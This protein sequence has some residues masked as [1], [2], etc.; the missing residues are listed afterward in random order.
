MKHFFL[1]AFGLVAVLVAVPAAA[2]IYEVRPD[3]TGDF[4]TIQAAVEAVEDGDVIELT[5]GTFRGDGNRD[6]AFLG[7]EITIRSQSGSPRSCFVDCE[8]S[9][10]DRHRGFL[11]V[12]SENLSSVLEGITI[13]GGYA[14]EGGAIKGEG[15]SPTILNC[16]F[17]GNNAWLGGAIHGALFTP[18]LED[19]HFESNNA[20]ATAGALF[21]DNGNVYLTR[22]SFKQNLAEAGHGGGAIYLWWAG[23][24]SVTD[25]AFVGNQATLGGAISGTLSSFPSEIVR[26]TFSGN[27]AYDSA[28]GAIGLVFGTLRLTD[29]LFIGN[30]AAGTHFLDGGGG[31]WLSSLTLEMSGCTIAQN[32]SGAPGGGFI[33]DDTDGPITVQNSTFFGNSAPEASGFYAWSGDQVLIENSSITFGIG[34]QAVMCPSDAVI[35]CCDIYGNEGG[36]WVGPLEDDYGINGN[37]AANPLFCDP[38]DVGIPTLH[39]QASPYSL[40]TDSPCL[41]GNHPDGYDC[42]LIG[43]HGPACGPSSSQT[44][45]KGAAVE[46]T[47]WGRVKSGYR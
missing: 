26:C 1:H 12:N 25:C 20:S 23:L 31:L 15:A 39:S 2:T 29:C 27:V 4:P 40:H 32:S 16:A 17:I 35:Q 7:K 14:Y 36:D 22:C 5:N 30:Q 19:C 8:G 41:P 38:D 47:T 28:G 45:D 10:G 6:V 9:S 3:G 13:K 18:W 43:A 44:G 46:V 24:R 42:G 21:Y 11:F 33:L 34:G 37:F